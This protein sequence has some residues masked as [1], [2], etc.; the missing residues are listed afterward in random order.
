MSATDDDAPDIERAT[1]EGW[2]LAE[3]GRF[4]KPGEPPQTLD[5]LRARWN[6]RPPVATDGDD[7]FS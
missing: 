6:P 1:D 7:G 2:L 3:D 5:D 4:E